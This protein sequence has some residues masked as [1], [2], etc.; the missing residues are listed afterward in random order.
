MFVQSIWN[1][2]IGTNKWRMMNSVQLQVGISI[3]FFYNDCAWN[4]Y[5]PSSRH[6]YRLCFQWLHG[7]PVRSFKSASASSS[8]P[9]TTAPGAVS[10][11]LEL[12]SN[13]NEDDL[14][15]SR[16][17]PVEKV[18]DRFL[19]FSLPSCG[20]RTSCEKFA[21]PQPFSQYDCTFIESLYS[22]HPYLTYSNKQS[23]SPVMTISKHDG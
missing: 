14:R 21:Y 16:V 6:Q 19:P 7:E 22:T 17:T 10:I 3:F 9:M 12:S 8:F 20:D 5:D 15:T 2:G 11:F 23:V 18:W 1:W 4:L 13:V